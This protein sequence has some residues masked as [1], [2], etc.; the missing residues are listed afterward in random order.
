MFERLV[1]FFG[2]SLMLDYRELVKHGAQ[3]ID[4]RTPSEFAAGHI[5]GSLNIPL[6][7]VNNHFNE[8]SRNRPLIVCCASGIRSRTA[9]HILKVKGFRN[10]YDAGSWM[11]LLNEIK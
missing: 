10:V 8:G 4:V 7:Q 1:K 6:W 11:S 2:S 9:R 3:I 5:P